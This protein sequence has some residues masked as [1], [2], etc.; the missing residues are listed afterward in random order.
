VSADVAAGLYDVT[1][2]LEGRT[3][4]KVEAVSEIL[5]FSSKVE[6]GL[7]R[8][9]LFDFE[10]DLQDWHMSIW[11]D[12]NRDPNGNLYHPY[13]TTEYASHGKGSLCMPVNL[14]AT[15]KSEALA[16]IS[17]STDW[18][19]LKK[20][21]IDIYLPKTAPEGLVA[22]FYCMGNRWKWMQTKDGVA[23]Q[24]GKWVTMETYL[25]GSRSAEEWENTEEEIQDGLAYVIDFGIRLENSE[26]KQPGYL[27][28]VYLDNF[29]V[30]PKSLKEEK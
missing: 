26:D 20:V 12:G 4:K 28:K 23:L 6:G 16:G 1:A 5:Y 3:L 7:N 17:P 21:S 10:K 11:P 30:E 19:M 13:Q 24:P 27:G 15:E 2:S 14:A 8:V 9:T 18:T 29:Q 22:K 25:A